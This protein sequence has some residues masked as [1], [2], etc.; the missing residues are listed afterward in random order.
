M[1]IVEGLLYLICWYLIHHIWHVFRMNIKNIHVVYD[2]LKNYKHVKYYGVTPNECDAHYMLTTKKR[3]IHIKL[4]IHC[5]T[6]HEMFVAETGNGNDRR[7]HHPFIDESMRT[8]K[9]YSVLKHGW[10]FY[11]LFY[12]NIG[13]AANHL[14]KLY[15]DNIDLNISFDDMDN[16]LDAEF[17]SHKR[18]SKIRKLQ[19]AL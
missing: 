7:A 16:E 2:F 10:Y 5:M 18:K 15:K 17:M 12:Y 19:E 13:K 6:L 1:I 4:S 14:E 3:V 9:R 8:Y 11:S